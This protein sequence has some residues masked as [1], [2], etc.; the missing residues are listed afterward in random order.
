MDMVYSIF[1]L[2]LK[3]LLFTEFWCS[4]KYGHKL[5]EKTMEIYFPFPTTYQAGFSSYASM[6]VIYYYRLVSEANMRIQLPF[7]KSELFIYLFFM[8]KCHFPP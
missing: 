5:S 7:I 4:I 2:T 3:K 1:Q 6:K 8:C